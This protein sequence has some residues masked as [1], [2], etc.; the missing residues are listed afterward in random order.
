MN[1]RIFGTAVLAALLAACAVPAEKPAPPPRVER[2][3]VAEIAAGV[4]R[5]ESAVDVLPLP[6]PEV[7]DL[8]RRAAASLAAGRAADAEATL[9]QA[10]ALRGEDPGL[11]QALAESLLAQARWDEA[12]AAAARSAELG[13]SVGALCLRSRYTAFAARIE[14]GDAVG[15][16]QARLRVEDC[17]AERPTRF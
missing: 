8:R 9:R 5:A 12:D 2:D 16:A 7:D 1:P 6:D 15:A 17:V 13:P 3:W 10:L 4:A 14:R 11:W